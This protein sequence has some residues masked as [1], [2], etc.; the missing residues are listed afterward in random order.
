MRVGVRSRNKKK[1]RGEQ[2]SNCRT[3]LSAPPTLRPDTALPFTSLEQAWDLKNRPPFVRVFGRFD[4]EGSG[5][6]AA[7]D[8][9]DRA[10]FY[11][12]PSTLLRFSFRLKSTHLLFF[13]VL[14]GDAAF[15]V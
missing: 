2:Q 14:L 15:F 8:V 11:I 3:R 7:S 4:P 9:R 5:N 13:L 6:M 1:I 12:T 10:R